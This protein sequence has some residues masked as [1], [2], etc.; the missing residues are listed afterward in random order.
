V[1]GAGV[2]AQYNY[3]LGSGLKRAILKML[4]D[5]QE[6]NRSLLT[7]ISTDEEIDAFHQALTYSGKTSV[8]AF[9]EHRPDLIDAGKKAIAAFLIQCEHTPG[10]FNPGVLD[11][12][13]DYLYSCMNAVPDKFRDNKVSIITYN[14]DRSLETY[15]VTALANSYCLDAE[16]AMQFLPQIIHLHGKLGDLP[17]ESESGR[18][19]GKIDNPAD[20]ERAAQSIRIIHD[21]SLE[22]EPQFT[23]AHK[24]LQEAAR[25]IFLGFGYDQTNLRR[26][27]L[28][29]L[30]HWT[31]LPPMYGSSFGFS[32]LEKSEIINRISAYNVTV[33][34][35]H[36][37]RTALQYLR[38]ELAL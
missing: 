3:P 25:V 26:L 15:L 14:Y 9:L 29:Y 6:K 5:P 7:H 13:Y 24:L 1:L 35:G 23:K 11:S 37:T 12:L 28:D 19:Y 36:P 18:P 38:E 17:W 20:V 16:T 27:Y 30:K 21:E 10:L 32:E 31:S 2:S 33:S 34:L 8:D 4:N 22:D